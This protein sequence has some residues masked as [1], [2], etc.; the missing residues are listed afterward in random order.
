MQIRT[1]ATT[2]SSNA[3][4][5]L[6]MNCFITWSPCFRRPTPT[7]SRVYGPQS[8]DYCGHRSDCLSCGTFRCVVPG[9]HSQS[10][11]ITVPEGHIYFN[12]LI[13]LS[14]CQ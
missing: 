9:L 2:D 5:V 8:S 10:V 11:A 1:I 7:A 13:W 3:K 14:F 12:S 6:S 4:P